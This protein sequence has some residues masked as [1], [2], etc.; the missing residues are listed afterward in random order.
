MLVVLGFV[1]INAWWVVG[2][3]TYWQHFALPWSQPLQR[4]LLLVDPPKA[5]GDYTFRNC[6]AEEFPAPCGG[7]NRQLELGRIGSLDEVTN[8]AR[9]Q[10][11]EHGIFVRVH[12]KHDHARV[13][14]G[15]GHP[16]RR[17]QG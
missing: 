7:S 13:R 6:R 4:G 16:C 2:I 5:C 17:V 12:G 1:T 15:T 14:E 9:A 8:C 3:V 10:R 11:H